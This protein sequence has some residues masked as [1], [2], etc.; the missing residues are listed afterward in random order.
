MPF[1][2]IRYLYDRC[3]SCAS[4]FNYRPYPDQKHIRVGEEIHVCKCGLRWRTGKRE[5]N[6]LSKHDK[7]IYLL[8]PR[9][10][11]LFFGVMWLGVFP[12]NWF[13]TPEQEKREALLALIAL[14]A[15]YCRPRVDQTYFYSSFFAS[16]AKTATTSTTRLVTVRVSRSA[17]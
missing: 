4:K 17:P 9:E 1:V 6:H 2:F 5:W 12:L 11:L 10:L 8:P 16:H 14:T 15:L 3:P 7:L 13:V